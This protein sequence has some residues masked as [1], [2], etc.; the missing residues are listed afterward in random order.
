MLPF[1]YVSSFDGSSVEVFDTERF[2]VEVKCSAIW[3]MS[4]DKYSNM[5]KKRQCWAGVRDL[6]IANKDATGIEENEFGK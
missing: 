5:G 6:F 3:D 4:C 1:L 2:I